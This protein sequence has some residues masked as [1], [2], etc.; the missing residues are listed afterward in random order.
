M[1]NADHV[2]YLL[3]LAD[4]ALMLSQRLSEWAGHG[5]V[6][7]EDI[8]L[9]NIALDLLGQ[10]RLLYQHAC[11]LGGAH[12]S[13][14]DLAYFRDTAE[15]RN[16]TMLELPNGGV[17]S[18]GAAEPDYAFTIVRNFLYSA[19]ALRLWQ[20]LAQ[21]KDSQLAA[22]AAK[23][24]KET[25]YHLRHAGDWLLRL[26]DGTAESHRR[27]QRALDALLPYSNEW[28]IGD[29]L[30]AAAAAAGVGVRCESLARPWQ[31]TV[32][33]VIGEATLRWPA[34]SKF[35]SSGKR[36][37]HSE[38]LGPLLAEMQSLARAHPGATW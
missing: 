1:D 12:Q 6:L 25:R 22:I 30:D 23:A 38:H 16:F 26:G 4:N 10:A 19:Y 36:G 2:Q 13:E 21:S 24:V 37:L 8:A 15:F 32:R 3:R 14:D 29:T 7:E 17:A 5:P 27:T 18:G 20:G 33:P 35:A 28:F 31:E 9:T 34:D 11:T